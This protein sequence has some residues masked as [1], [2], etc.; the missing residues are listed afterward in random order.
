MSQEKP[1]VKILNAIESL[2][3]D[4]LRLKKNEINEEEL[5]TNNDF[6][7]SNYPTL[8]SKVKD[9]TL[10]MEIINTMLLS[11]DKMHSGSQS[12]HEASVDVGTLLRD[13]IVIPGMKKRGQDVTINNNISN[14]SE[15]EAKK[16]V[17]EVFQL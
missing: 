17:N 14:L 12:E 9:N 13:K 1:S 7:I 8:A 16:K 11:L 10:D 15:E 3:T 4:Y 2:K 6:L 5:N